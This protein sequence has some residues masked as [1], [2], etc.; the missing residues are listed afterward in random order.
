M[1]NTINP[2]RSSS[3]APHRVGGMTLIELLIGLVIGM[4]TVLAVMQISRQAET[5]RRNASVGADAQST[6]H[7]ASVSLNREISQAGGILS[8]VATSCTPGLVWA[9]Y[10]GVDVSFPAPVLPVV[11]SPNTVDA[12]WGDRID[13]V[14]TLGPLTSW[15]MPMKAAT[16][17]SYSP[18]TLS[19][20]EGYMSGGLV[21]V[22][23]PFTATSSYGCLL[24]QV[25]TVTGASASGNDL[26]DINHTTTGC[27]N[28]AD[29]TAPAGPCRYNDASGFPGGLVIPDGTSIYSLGA[30]ENHHYQVE[31]PGGATSRLMMGVTP[32]ASGAVPAMTELVDGVVFFKAYYGFDTTSKPDGQ[33]DL[34]L[35]AGNCTSSA[36]GWACTDGTHSVPNDANGSVASRLIAVRIGMVTRNSQ[37]DKNLIDP[38]APVS[39]PS[40][41]KL[42]TWGCSA[43][44]VCPSTDP[45]YT[46]PATE[47][48]FRY[49]VYQTTIPLRNQVWNQKTEW[50]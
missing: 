25:T 37:H 48:D 34:W 39:P 18:L 1:V 23:Y 10:N 43:P 19:S 30:V 35:S 17:G 6:M 42:W 27:L 28:P 11:I 31:K 36:A 2:R 12:A 5:W 50:D 29:A 32:F 22:A 21:L 20:P 41:Y 3:R 24:T 38:S 8:R 16:V 13:V 45:V 14:R 7:V 26:F 15:L 49:R 46:V 40:S 33:V 47:L 9:R 44:K 4:M